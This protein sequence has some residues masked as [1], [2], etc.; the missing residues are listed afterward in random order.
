MNVLPGMS[1]RMSS[2][3]SWIRFARA[4]ITLYFILERLF[5]WRF[6]SLF[7]PGWHLIPVLRTGMKSSLD[8]F[9]P[10]RNH[11]SSCRQQQ[12]NDQTPRWIHL[13]TKVIPGRKL[14]CKEALKRSLV[15]K[16]KLDAT[17]RKLLF[18]VQKHRGGAVKTCHV[19]AQNVN[20]FSWK[21]RV[22]KRVLPVKKRWKNLAVY[23]RS[24]M[25]VT[26]AFDK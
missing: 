12:E 7:I 21:T 4:N 8:E 18:H 25:V 26:L 13:G 23:G 9:I 22:E 19:H 17:F 24:K 14:S 1:G 6:S 15:C 3:P 20:W 5:T 16:I 2:R 11:V 10:G